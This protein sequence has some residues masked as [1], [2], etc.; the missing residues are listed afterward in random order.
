MCKLCGWWL[1][2]IVAEVQ[3]EQAGWIS[4]NPFDA[5]MSR[6]ILNVAPQPA[7][8]IANPGSGVPKTL[9][10]VPED[11]K[12][13]KPQTGFWKIFN[14]KPGTVS[15]LNHANLTDFNITWQFCLGSIPH[16]Q[17]TLGR[18]NASASRRKDRGRRR[19]P[20]A[21]TEAWLKCHG[22]W[23]YHLSNWLVT[24]VTL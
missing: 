6:K 20:V 21:C 17:T 15:R 12:H 3:P 9:N 24:L 16:C 13:L 10:Q 1:F 22:I 8:R 4:W 18:W 19:F 7:V 14:F 2:M 11:L 23:N 5:E